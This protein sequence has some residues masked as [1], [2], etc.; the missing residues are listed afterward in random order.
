MGRP[1]D[2]VLIICSLRCAGYAVL[3]TPYWLRDTHCAMHA[4]PARGDPA[5]LRVHRE[6]VSDQGEGG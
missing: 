6:D 2:A 4:A 5:L 1:R 3:A